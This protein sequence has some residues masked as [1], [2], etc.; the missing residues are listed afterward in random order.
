VCLG[1]FCNIYRLDNA[2][3]I[4][5]MITNRPSKNS[6]PPQRKVKMMANAAP[7]NHKK[8]SIILP[9]N[10]KK[11]N[12]PTSNINRRMISILVV[13]NFGKSRLQLIRKVGQNFI[14]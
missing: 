6:I 13:D 4:K 5:K 8:N 12:A 11:I 14:D 1:I 2:I 3:E 9:N 10:P 7:K